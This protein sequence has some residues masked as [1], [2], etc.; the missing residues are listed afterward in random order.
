M[1]YDVIVIG[2][3]LA[4]LSSALKLSQNGKKVAVFEKH[5]MPGGYATNFKR[6]DKDGNWYVFDVA[7]HG[8]GGL[9]PDNIFYN[10]MKNI[11]M[12]DK[13]GLIR[14][15]ETGTIYNHNKEID[16]PDTFEKYRDHLVNRYKQYEKNIFDLFEE[17]NELNEELASGKAPVIYQK[18]QNITL[19]DYLKSFIDDNDFIEEFSF[20]W[21]YYGLP[22]KK[23]NALYYMMA[24][25][26]YHMGGTFYIKGGAGKLSDTFAEEIKNNGG[27]IYLSNEI[28]KIDVEGK[29]VTA[30][31]TKKGE[32]YQADQFIFACDPNHLI[33]LMDSENE[34]VVNYKAKLNN[35]EVGI[36]LS[37]LYIGLDCK[38]TDV[39]I[40]KADYF[41]KEVDDDTAFNNAM[42]GNYSKTVYGVTSYDILDPELNKDVGV[43]VVVIGDNIK[44]WPEYKSD[45]YKK[46]KED[47]TKELLE[48]VYNYFPKVKGHVKVLELGT[49]HTMK[50]Y[51][52]NTDGAVY[53]WDQNIQQGGFN[54]L[55]NKSDFSNVFLAGAWAN[56]GGGFEGAITGGILTAERMLRESEKNN[57]NIKEDDN[58]YGLIEPDMPLKQFMI[59]M[60]ANFNNKMVSNEDHFKLEFVFDN[61]DKFYVEIKNRKA[62]LLQKENDKKSDVIINTS[63]KVWY[64]IAFNRLNGKDAMF[65]GNLSILG[66]KNIFM[67]IPKYFNTDSLAEDTEIEVKKLNPLFWLVL[68]LIPWIS[69][70]IISKFYHNPTAIALSSILYTAII[71]AFVKPKQFKKITMLE[72]MTFISFSLYGLVYTLM[73]SIFNCIGKYMLD[74]MLILIFLISALVK[75][76]VTSDYSKQA[77]KESMTR[78]K[79][80]RDININLTFLWAFIFGVEFILKVIAPHPW[81]N[82]VYIFALIGLIISYY[83]PK[84][85]L[86]E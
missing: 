60:V 39:G 13:I 47:V 79:L 74:I 57:L 41:I 2:G 46:K 86:G 68:T 23:L 22:P 44:N 81:N 24:W 31:Y 38:T 75:K 73:P 34:N 35:N 52:N 15:A 59:G 53:G 70:G 50:R 66:D 16:V 56:P 17:I 72:T 32:K 20:L 29:K 64:N 85:K 6:R 82:F 7:L 1:K 3:G 83:Y 69:T 61:K 67:N 55:S 19:Y 12:I 5:F 33:N 65:D 21:L 63:Y 42:N 37:Q 28:V 10:H 77:Y 51:T 62:K 26:S 8:I 14:K 40:N 36:S 58:E 43:F 18:L 9:L 48:V 71:I 80:F 54:R 11:D 45:E 25:I 76:P 27:K 4:G 49:P 84:I 30:I 78:T